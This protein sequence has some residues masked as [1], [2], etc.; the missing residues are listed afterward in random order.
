MNIDHDDELNNVNAS[1]VKPQPA[2]VAVP[3][4][5]PAAKPIAKPV[6]TD[7]DEFVFGDEKYMSGSKLPRII[8]AKG[9]VSRFFLVDGVRP[10]AKETHYIAGTG[11][12]QCLGNGCPACARESSRTRIVAL[13][14]MYPNADKKFGKLGS[15]KPTYELGWVSLSRANYTQIS[16]IIEENSTVYSVDYKMSHS[17]RAFGYEFSIGS[18]IAAYIKVGDQDVIAKLAAEY[19]DGVELSRKLGKKVSA[20]EMR[21]ALAGKDS[22]PDVVAGLEVLSDDLD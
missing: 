21:S 18:S 6:E 11:T 15:Q 3:A 14:C 9:E 2:P 13:A 17:T 20:S 5:K 16:T 8:P 19:L 7:G 4:T 12:L 1:N 22:A 10:R